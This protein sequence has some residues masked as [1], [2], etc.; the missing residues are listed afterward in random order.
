MVCGTVPRFAGGPLTTGLT[1]AIA[2]SISSRPMAS[3]RGGTSAARGTRC[4]WIHSAS[5]I[6]SGMPMCRK[7]SSEKSR[8]LTASGEMKLRVRMPLNTGSASIHSV[9]AMTT[10]CASWSQGSMKPLT[11][12]AYTSQSTTTPDTHEKARKLR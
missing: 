3:L 8:S 1:S 11:P 5:S 4:V 12:E 9:V 7:D 10:N 6:T 2:S